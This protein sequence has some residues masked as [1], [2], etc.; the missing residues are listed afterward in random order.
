MLGAGG[1]FLCA[2]SCGLQGVSKGE[3]LSISQRAQQLC[4]KPLL[5]PGG[6]LGRS[7]VPPMQ[8]FLLLLNSLGGGHTGEGEL[9]L[10]S[11]KVSL[12]H[13]GGGSGRA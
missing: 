11:G 8:S 1:S 13:A 7:W 9:S 10:C 12:Q 2:A 3:E 4:T 6:I 5:K